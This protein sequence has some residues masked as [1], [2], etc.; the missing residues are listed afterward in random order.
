MV[1]SSTGNTLCKLCSTE[2]YWEVFCASFLGQS[3]TGTF[4]V[5]ALRYKVVRGTLCA[6]FV[7]QS[8]TGKCLVQALQCKVELGSALCKLCSTKRHLEVL[9]ASFVVPVVPHKAVAEVSEKETC[10]RGWLLRFTDG[11]ANPLLRLLELCFLEWLQRLQRHLT[12]NCCM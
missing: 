10:R 3:T 5:E 1:Q 6:S 11:R 9:C 8:S 2:W 4:F 12:H 7:V